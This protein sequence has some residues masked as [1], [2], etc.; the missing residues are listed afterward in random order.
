MSAIGKQVETEGYALVRGC[1]DE[2]AIQILENAIDS[3]GAGVRNLL[4]NQVVG[5]VAGSDEV[6]NIAASVLGTSCFAVR[7]IFF[8]KS[9]Q[10]NWKVTWHQDCVI[11]VREKLDIEG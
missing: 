1:V 3:D 9:P 5:A 4:S 6:R 8:N 11:A 7:G 2:E 10:A